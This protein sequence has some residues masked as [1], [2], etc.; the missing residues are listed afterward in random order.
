MVARDD[1]VI[2]GSLIA[3]GV[4]L[5]LS[6]ALNIFFWQWGD[7]QAG[8]ATAA[9]ERLT[10]TQ[11]NL[12]DLRIKADLLKSMLGVGNSTSAERDELLRSVDGDE[13][14]TPI[15]DRYQTDM[16]LIGQEV[17]PQN[18]NYTALPKFFADSLRS[19]NDVVAQARKDVTK[20][21]SDAD[22]D[23]AAAKAA[24]AVAETAA[25]AAK[26]ELAD[27]Q[28]QFQNERADMKQKTQEIQD[29]LTIAQ[30]D[31]TKM[32]ATKNAE[33]SKLD[34]QLAS[35]NSIVESQ[36]QEINLLKNDQFE[37][38]QGQITS[39]QG[40]NNGG[41]VNISLGSSR[42]IAFGRDVFGVLSGD[43]LRP[44]EAQVKATIQVV[45]VRGQHI[46]EARV[47]SRP[48]YSNPITTG[49]KVYSP[50]WSPGRR[51]KI[52]LIGQIDIDG[53]GQPDNDAVK[54]Q[55]RAVGAEVVEPRVVN[56]KVVGLG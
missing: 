7:T 56:G 35:A 5:V 42:R 10:T 37:V 11:R 31:K 53:D 27:A 48:N 39:V 21:R 8:T 12:G 16:A 54:S 18:Q 29:R 13:E 32:E 26:N 19:K 52:A 50:F 14:M 41:I 6:I 34:R 33:I 1:S 4:L 38:F 43:A 28:A 24:L 36:R 17:D 3:V 15:I 49:D 25:T 22:S 44:D 40:R 23:V 55:I 30:T 45:K 46:S 47:V 9:N 2:R 51:V 20:A